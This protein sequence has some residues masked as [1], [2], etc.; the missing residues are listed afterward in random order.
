MSCNGSFRTRVLP[1]NFVIFSVAAFIYTPEQ[2]L[3]SFLMFYIVVAPLIKKVVDSGAEIKS[4][5]IISIKHTE[6]AE[7]IH[8][9]FNRKVIFTDAHKDDLSDD[10]KIVT[11]FVPR[12]EEAMLTNWVE[13]IDDK[14][15]V[16]VHDAS[17]VR[18]SSLT[19]TSSH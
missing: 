9:K 14:A 8:K 10:L 13:E 2:A 1:C 16:I 4:I 7:M 11:V 17:I 18:S 12:M 6:I 3:G 5:Q 19:G 15:I